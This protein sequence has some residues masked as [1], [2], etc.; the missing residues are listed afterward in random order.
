MGILYISLDLILTFF[1]WSE[2][3]G[4]ETFLQLLISIGHEVTGEWL[5]SC[6]DTSKNKGDKTPLGQNYNH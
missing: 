3:R 6:T 5:P 1:H 4:V 2:A